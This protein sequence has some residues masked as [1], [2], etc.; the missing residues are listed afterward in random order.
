MK[1][2]ITKLL[3]QKD[4]N[5]KIIM[6]FKN[7]WYVYIVNISAYVHQVTKEGVMLYRDFWHDI[8]KTSRILIH[9]SGHSPQEM[10]YGFKSEQ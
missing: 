5:I 10:M 2:L 7:Y 1:M 8:D 4:E 9:G 3:L 6:Y